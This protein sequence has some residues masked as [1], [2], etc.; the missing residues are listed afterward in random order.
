MILLRLFLVCLVFILW[1]HL[2]IW[3]THRSRD[4]FL[5]AFKA[6]LDVHGQSRF[7][8]LRST[9]LAIYGLLR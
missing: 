8:E 2:T 9:N 3:L 1:I 5:V 4:S 6:I 7:G